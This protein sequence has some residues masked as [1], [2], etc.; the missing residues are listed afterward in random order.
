MMWELIAANRRRSI[1]L[2]VGMAALLAALGY[3]I[4]EVAMRGGG[5]TGLVVAGGVWLVL[6]AAS[7]FGGSRVVLRMSRAHEVS[8]EVH[9]RLFNVVEE[10]RIA[11]GLE[12]MPRVCII[13]EPAPNA[14]A[15]G[16]SPQD[17]TIVVTAGL[18]ERLDRDELQGVVAHEMSHIVNRDMQFMTLAGI[19]VGTIVLVSEV[20]LRTMWYSGGGASRR[21]R[22]GRDGGGGGNAIVIVAAVVMAILGP[23]FARL[24]YFAISRRREYLADACAARL[25]RYPEGLASALEKLAAERIPL[26]AASGATAPLYIV[27]PLR[28]RAKGRL[29]AL[30]ATHPPIADRIAVLR[31]MTSGAALSDYQSAWERIHGAGSSVLPPSARRRDERV[32][33]RAPSPSET[34]EGAPE[35][36]THSVYDLMRAVNGFTFLAC[37]CGLRMK[38]PPDWGDEPVRCP[39]CGRSN[40]VPRATG[41]D[42]ETIAAA[43]AAAAAGGTGAGAAAGV[44]ATAGTGA[45]IGMARARRGSAA[46][47]L[48][49]ARRTRGWESFAC[50]CG[51]RFQLSPAFRG[52]HVRCPRCDRITRIRDATR[53]NADG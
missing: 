40:A 26:R 12:H 44:G 1:V 42:G 46:P 45:G 3:L 39:R 23:V 2:F 25:T 4:G 6:A 32:S 17:A 50:V 24:L 27:A 33:L 14:F 52:S 53:S 16:L 30:G 35:R 9:P 37:A 43:L 38:L 51:H 7:A 41:P 31:A 13:D 8:H 5:R 48:E 28:E 29:E 15:T 34:R 11:A 10:M 49:Y 47:V 22:S 21:Y 19:M 18:L 20:F 36:G